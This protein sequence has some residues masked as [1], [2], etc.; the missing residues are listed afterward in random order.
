MGAY[1]PIPWSQIVDREGRDTFDI[2]Q[3]IQDKL[4]LDVV[5]MQWPAASGRR[6]KGV[7]DLRTDD[8]L[9][10]VKPEDGGEHIL[11]KVDGNSIAGMFDNDDLLNEFLEEQELAREYSAG[12]RPRRVS[13]FAAQSL[14]RRRAP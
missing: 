5:P 2:I 13:A 12:G 11:T 1:P 14:W 6:F 7:V 9:H 8:F 4:A 3:E 10:F